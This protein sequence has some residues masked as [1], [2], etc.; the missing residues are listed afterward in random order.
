MKKSSTPATS[1]APATKKPAAAAKTAAPAAK[2]AARAPRA[3]AAAPAPVDPVNPPANADASA[4]TTITA[5]IDV[6]FGNTLFLRGEGPSLSWNK[7]LPLKN[8]GADRWTISLP[9]A[10][11]PIVFKFL[12][13][14]ETWSTGDDFRA[15]PGATV[16][17]RPVF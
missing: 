8:D 9:R 2:T 10:S 3:K 1:P 14:D 5:Q 13:N 15:D 6:G 17:L 4:F 11:Q 7:G 16:L 12:L